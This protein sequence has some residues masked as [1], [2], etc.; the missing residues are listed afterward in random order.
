MAR[1][2]PGEIVCW[3]QHVE[4]LLPVLTARGWPV[5]G[6][7]PETDTNAR[8]VV[9]ALPGQGQLHLIVD[10]DS[11]VVWALFSGPGAQAAFDSIR[12]EALLS[13][14]QAPLAELLAASWPDLQRV[15]VQVLRFV[16]PLDETPPISRALEALARTATDR[17]LLLAVLDTTL[18]LAWASAPT[19][20]SAVAG[21]ED[22]DDDLRVAARARL[23]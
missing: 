13:T 5:I 17:S 7:Q 9:W 21:R 23:V 10:P 18:R 6:D 1:Y 20:L 4:N 8:E 12:E 19:V 14:W 16:A 3:A 2:E 22:V 11:R 15:F